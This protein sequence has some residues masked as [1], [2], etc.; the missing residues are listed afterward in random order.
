MATGALSLDRALAVTQR[1]LGHGV[2]VTLTEGRGATEPAPGPMPDGRPPH[3]R[4]ADDRRVT[5]QLLCG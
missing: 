3:Q 5:V 2:V 4:H 1:L